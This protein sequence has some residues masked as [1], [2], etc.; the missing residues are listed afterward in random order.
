MEED[1]TTTDKHLTLHV[2]RLHIELKII[3]A[4]IQCK[5]PK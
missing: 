1:G 2:G 4:G 5:M 3:V